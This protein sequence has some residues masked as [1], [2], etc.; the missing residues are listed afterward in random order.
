[1]D[2]QQSLIRTIWKPP[3]KVGT[4]MIIKGNIV[5]IVQLND[6]RKRV[7]YGKEVTLTDVEVFKSKDL[8]NAIRRNWVEVIFDRSARKPFPVN[9]VQQVRKQTI[10]SSQ[11]KDK[12]NQEEMI[13]LAKQMAQSM[14][15]EMLKNSS[16][17]KDIAKEVAKEMTLELKDSF[18]VQQIVTSSAQE[19]KIQVSNPDNV[20]ID[21]K[22]DEVQL[23]SSIKGL[24]TVE[25]QKDDLTGS[26]EKMKRFKRSK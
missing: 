20:F 25:V 9:Q 11:V 16:L 10:V 7:E 2:F 1:M 5:N 15:Q 23:K 14:A 6:I 19:N 18:K 12:M 21:F 22:D 26:L 8:K 24:G 17:V 4:Y 3:R 13:E